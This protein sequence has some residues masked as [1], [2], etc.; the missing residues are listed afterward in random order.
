LRVNAD[1]QPDRVRELAAR[2]QQWADSVGVISYEEVLAARAR[3]PE[4]PA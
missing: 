2:W 1:T 3:M 4:Q